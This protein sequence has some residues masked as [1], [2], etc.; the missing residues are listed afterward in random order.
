MN[1]AIIN[2]DVSINGRGEAFMPAVTRLRAL[3]AELK[4]QGCAVSLTFTVVGMEGYTPEEVAHIDS[5]IEDDERNN[6]RQA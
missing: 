6:P 1:T 3:V 4:Q 2:I 5:I